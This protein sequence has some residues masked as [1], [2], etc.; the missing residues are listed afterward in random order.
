MVNT[1]KDTAETDSEGTWSE[2][3][4]PNVMLKDPTIPRETWIYKLHSN[5][6]NDY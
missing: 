5:P 6:S 3:Q 2:T 1:I 4:I